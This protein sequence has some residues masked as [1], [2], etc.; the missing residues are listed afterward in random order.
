MRIGAPL[1]GG[2]AMLEPDLIWGVAYGAHGARELVEGDECTLLE[3][4]SF[5]WLHVNLVHRGTR[6]WIEH[7]SDL[8]MGIRELLLSSDSHQREVVDGAAVGC[9][10]SDF[11]RDFDDSQS[12]RVGAIRIAITDRLFLSARV[13]PVCAADIARQRVNLGIALNSSAAALDLLVGAVCQGIAERAHHLGEQLRVAEDAVLEDK[14]APASR[15]LMRMRQRL[16]RLHRLLDGIYSVFRRLEEDE[17]LPPHM[18]P[19]AEKL[20]Q[21]LAS[22][23][24]DVLGIQSQL[25][26]LREEIDMQAAQRTNQNLY[27]LSIMTA[28]M[29]PATLVTGIFGMNTGD[30]PLVGAHGT[31]VATIIAAAAAGL[32]YALLRWMGFMR[33]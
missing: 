6:D 23:D 3:G 30:L 8:P 20:S 29:L 15:D 4:E 14:Q 28:L 1:T 5:C 18:Q 10:I 31:I 25:R 9:V 13:H 27:I 2:G 24:R 7:Y 17:D 32:A 19:V 22:L 21:R 16:A 12:E 33:L 11:E 26:L